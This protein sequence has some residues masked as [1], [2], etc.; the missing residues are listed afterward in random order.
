MRTSRLAT[1]IVLGTLLSVT[2]VGA[3]AAAGCSSLAAQTAKCVTAIYDSAKRNAGIIAGAKLASASAWAGAGPEALLLC[4]PGAF[5]I[6]GLGYDPQPAID[7]N[8]Q[9]LEEQQATLDA[10]LADAPVEAFAAAGAFGA[11]AWLNTQN[12]F[13]RWNERLFNPVLGK[14]SGFAADPGLP[15]PSG[16]DFSQASAEAGESAACVQ[17]APMPAL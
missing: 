5:P 3:P 8:L 16:F 13:Q 10:F 1:A 11:A 6:P 9:Y 17:A 12:V 4:P 15:D 14:V 2:I 7:G